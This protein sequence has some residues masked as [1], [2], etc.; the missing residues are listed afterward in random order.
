M[1]RSHPRPRCRGPDRLLQPGLR[2]RRQEGGRQD[3]CRHR[4]VLWRR[5]RRQERLRRRRRHHLRR[6]LEGRLPGQRLEGRAQGH[7]RRDEDAQGQRLADAQGLTA[8]LGGPPHAGPDRR[9]RPQGR[10]L[11]GGAG[12]PGARP[13]V[14]GP[15]RELPG[16]GRPAAGLAGSDPRGASAVAARRLAVARRRRAAR[17]AHPVAAS[18]HWCAGS[19]R[20]WS[21]STWPG[22][23]A[24]RT[25]CPTCCRSRAATKRWRPSADHVEQAQEALGRTIALENPSHYLALDGHAWSEIDFLAEIA[26]RTGCG[27]LLDIA[28]VHVSARNTG[29]SAEAYVDAFPAERVVEIHLAGHRPDAR[30]GDCLL[31]RFARCAGGR[32]GLGAVPALRRPGRAAADADRARCRRCRPSPTLLGERHEAHDRLAASMVAR[33]SDVGWLRRL[34][35]STPSSATSPP[36]CSARRRAKPAAPW[37]PQ[38]G[39]AVYRNTVLRGCID[40]LA[41]QLPDR[42]DA[43]RSGVVRRS[44]RPLRA[45]QPAA[46]R[47]P[48]RLWRRLRRVP[49]AARASRPGSTTSA[50]SPASIGPGPKP[51]SRPMRR[52][53]KPRRSPLWSPARLLGAVLVPHPAARWCRLAGAA[54]L[55]HLAPPSRA[56]VARGRAR[57]AGRRRTARPGPRRASSGRKWK[58]RRRL[59]SMPAPRAGPSRDGGR[60]GL[61]SRRRS[62][63]RHLA[64]GAGRRPAPSPASSGDDA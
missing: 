45:D 26:R 15:C 63:H 29:L 49:G 64:A 22:L 52:C 46:R 42:G 32:S 38:P 4:E 12:L 53:C 3:R 30:L 33:L 58:R 19:S 35:P 51:I 62:R 47:Q 59:S 24:G 14:R 44:G 18:P 61:P 28:N 5:P 8:P 39:F 56:G 41:R 60:A 16:R 13:V 57:L 27:L 11:P 20:R 54:D 37:P 48:R 6:D 36:P 7:L 1:N 17:R 34:R 55:R 50:V 21:R 40:A 10:S 25:T 23:D 9:A 31:D 2:R 43:G